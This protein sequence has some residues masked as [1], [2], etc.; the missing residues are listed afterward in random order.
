MGQGGADRVTL[1]LLQSFDRQQ[2]APTLILMYQEGAYLED[3]PADVP[4]YSLGGQRLWTAWRPLIHL[5]RLHRPDIVFSTSSGTNVIA[6]LAHKLAW[7]R[8]RLVLSE[9]NVLLH[10]RITPKKRLLL[11]AKRLLYNQ[12]DVVT[13]VSEGVQAD[14]LT[15]LHLPPEKIQVVYN[16]IVTPDLPALA[17][18]AITHPWFAEEIPI[19]LGVGRLV[20]EKDF[21]TLIKAVAK[22]RE[23]RPCRLLILGEGD[24]RHELKQLSQELGI[25]E[26]VCLP[27]FDKN[28]FKYMA[29]CTVFVLSSR[30]EGLPGALIQAMACGAAVIATDCPSGP[31]EIIT[32]GKDGLLIPVGDVAAMARCLLELLDSPDLRATLG[33]QAQQSAQRF[34]VEGVLQKYVHALTAE[35]GFL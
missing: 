13:A 29:R 9:R 5:L 26:A 22:V 6:V 16:P 12:A 15:K 11:W 1:T 30:F 4:I 31:S 10:G 24:G 20:A 14:L 34:Q 35:T 21:P 32:P 27:G 7:Q 33:Q 8:G 19:I 28:P 2:F 17:A 25:A 3:L 18:E 23:Q